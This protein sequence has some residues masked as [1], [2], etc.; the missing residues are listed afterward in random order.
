M[1]DDLMS[2]TIYLTPYDPDPAVPRAAGEL[3]LDPAAR[4]LGVGT[5][6]FTMDV[7]LLPQRTLGGD[8]VR[9]MSPEGVEHALLQ[10]GGGGLPMDRKLWVLPGCAPIS[11]AF[12]G[13][14]S[15]RITQI[16]L[17]EP[18]QLIGLRVRSNGGT[19]TLFVKIRN[20]ANEE[21][22]SHDFAINGAMM[23]E[24]A[25]D[26]QLSPGYYTVHAAPTS[27]NFLLE[28]VEAMTPAATAPQFHLVAMRFL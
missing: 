8:E 5:D 25:F 15:E 10:G 4:V 17:G 24:P 22:L 9:L 11:V 16:A 26:L 28:Q 18:A 14:P 13:L 12:L 21:V 1:G 27:S 6:A 7:P 20:A 19:G 3:T 2:D 23:L